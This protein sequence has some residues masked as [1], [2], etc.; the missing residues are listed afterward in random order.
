MPS[1]SIPNGI[2]EALVD[3]YAGGNVFW[4]RGTGH[5]K[6]AGSD[7]GSSNGT[8]TKP[9]AT[10]DY[11][12]GRCTANQGDVIM[13]MPGYVQTVTAT[14]G[15]TFDVAGVRVVGLG[16]ANDRPTITYNTDASADI[17]ITADDVVLENFIHVSTLADVTGPIR[18]TGAGAN[19][20][21]HSFR[22]SGSGHFDGIFDIA[23]ADRDCDYLTIKHCSYISTDTQAFNFIE[24]ANDVHYLVIE[25]CAHWSLATATVEFMSIAAGASIFGALIQ[26]VYTHN[27]D[28]G[29]SISLI[30]ATDQ[31]DNTGIV[32][33]CFCN[34]R[35]TLGEL[36]MTASAGM[37]FLRCR[38]SSVIDK[39]GYTLP[40]VDA[41]D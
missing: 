36:L 14:G 16:N 17:S 4:V 7:S 25:D 12:V 34:T 35:D 33:D 9:F 11:A 40:S 8:R 28:T 22:D 41:I 23:G 29:S 18:V 19:F 37:Q 30:V 24:I 3:N 27:L 39:Q 26:R 1:P 32:A 31:T 5:G 21:N 20:I 2:S 6:G 10:I 15:I 38:G 13:V